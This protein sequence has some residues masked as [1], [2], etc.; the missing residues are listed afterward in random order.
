MDKF[1]ILG[2]FV[3]AIREYGLGYN[4]GDGGDVARST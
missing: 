3:A 2:A 4:G 1:M